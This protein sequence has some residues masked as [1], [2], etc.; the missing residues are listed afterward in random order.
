M[1]SN[2][3]RP[4]VHR[5]AVCDVH[6]RP[7]SNPSWRGP[8]VGHRDIPRWPPRPRSDCPRLRVAF[9]HTHPTRFASEDQGRPELPPVGTRGD[10]LQKR[11]GFRAGFRVSGFPWIPRVSGFPGFA[12]SPQ[13]SGCLDSAQGAAE[14]RV[15]GFRP[16][17]EFRVSGFCLGFCLCRWLSNAHQGRP[18]CWA[19]KNLARFASLN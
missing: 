14:V 5:P 19:D 6:K 9:R 11:A 3:R 7:W 8:C 1:S 17:A 10:Q 4:D 16:V 15:S 13:K 18:L 2:G 12:R